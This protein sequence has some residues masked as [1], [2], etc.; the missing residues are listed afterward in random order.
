[1]GSEYMRLEQHQRGGKLTER[2]ERGGRILLWGRTMTE[3][4]VK[5]TEEGRG[6]PGAER[7]MGSKVLYQKDDIRCQGRFLVAMVTLCPKAL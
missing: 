5:K 2:G 3:K 7:M 6:A 1:M 4:A